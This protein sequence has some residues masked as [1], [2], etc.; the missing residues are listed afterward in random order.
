ETRANERRPSDRER[1]AD[2]KRAEIA[3]RL[4]LQ[5]PLLGATEERD[6]EDSG[7]VEADDPD[8][9]PP[10]APDPPPIAEQ[11]LSSRA[12]RGPERDEDQREAEHEGQRV[13]QDPAA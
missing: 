13:H 9:P 7:D 8:E 1:D 3:G 5:L 11:E 4:F 12:E 2:Q 10:D 6:S